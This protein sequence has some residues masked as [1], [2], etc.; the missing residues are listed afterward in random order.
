MHGGVLR[1]TDPAGL[2]DGDPLA[3]KQE[4]TT[5]AMVTDTSESTFSAG[6]PDVPAN[7]Q[8][9]DGF[10]RT[11]EFST[12]YCTAQ[13]TPRPAIPGNAA[14][15]TRTQPHDAPV[16][17]AT[18]QEQFEAAKIGMWNGVVDLATALTAG[19]NP[20]LAEIADGMIG[21]LRLPPPRLTGNALHDYELQGSYK[22]GGYFTLT[23]SMALPMAGEG[24]GFGVLSSE[25]SGLF[26][27]EEAAAGAGT[28]AGGAASGTAAEGAEASLVAR[29]EQIHG[30]LD[31]TAQG[32]RTTAVLDTSAGRVVASGGRDLTPGQ[33]ALLQAGEMYNV[34]PG[35]HAEVTAITG[36]RQIGAQL[37][38]IG[39]TR[40]F[41]PFCIDYIE[42]SGG[43]I[44][45]PRTAVWPQ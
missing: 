15:P 23:V 31:T 17:L 39:T 27:V 34:A 5:G 20:K 30:A 25:G 21:P 42:Q 40:D 11:I 37:R 3:S 33:R 13:G 4:P 41:C 36:A 28:A 24:E 14:P 16:R 32:M 9:D 12:D 8:N 44:T 22:G 18:E 7:L 38:A 45:G 43:M 26:G 35:V 6:N 1:A 2:D 19:T 10:N 29:A